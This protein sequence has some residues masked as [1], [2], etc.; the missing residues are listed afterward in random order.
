M[1]SAAITYF[2]EPFL[3]AF[4]PTLRKGLGVWYTPPEIVR[5]LLP[6]PRPPNYG[7]YRRQAYRHSHLYADPYH[8]S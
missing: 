2:Y 5:Y 4:D 1:T 6:R 7:C 8:N 3:Q